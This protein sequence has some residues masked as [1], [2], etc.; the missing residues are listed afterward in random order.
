MPFDGTG[1]GWLNRATWALVRWLYA[2]LYCNFWDVL[3][4]AGWPPAFDR[5]AN[6]QSGVRLEGES[7]ALG[8][9]P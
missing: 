7:A 4:A 9:S 5:S 1:H 6:Q 3:G 8:E 2:Y